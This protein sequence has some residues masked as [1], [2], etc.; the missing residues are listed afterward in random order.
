MLGSLPLNARPIYLFTDFGVS[1]PWLGQMHAAIRAFASAAEVVNLVADAPASDPFLSAY[2]L[3][4]CVAPLPAGSIVLCV[5]DPGVG[6]ERAALVID[7]G[8]RSYI[9]PDNGL[10]SRVLDPAA[11]VRR[12]LWRPGA[13]S[14]SFH[15]RDLFAPLA[16]MLAQGVPF[17][18]AP[19]PVAGMVGHDWE[20]A[21]SRVIYVDH[22]G[23][24]MTG[25][26]AG[27]VATHWSVRLN[28]QAISRARTFSDVPAGQGFWYVNALGRV[29]IAV[30]RGRADRI[31]G[32]APGDAIG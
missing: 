11:R 3:A 25:L 10:L 5:V 15:G 18:T 16:G 14:D 4:A 31:L 12:V 23:N 8:G 26:R 21:L 22:F 30:N 29:E 6:T 28:G 27:D 9:G 24:L 7:S 1:G 32:L 20:A 13:L 17:E 19:L 2:L